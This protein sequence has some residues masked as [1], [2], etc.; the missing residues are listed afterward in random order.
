[1]VFE[2]G[3]PLVALRE[4]RARELKCDRHA[5]ADPAEVARARP[6]APVLK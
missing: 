4:Q 3:N 2:K 6:S 1:M 5:E